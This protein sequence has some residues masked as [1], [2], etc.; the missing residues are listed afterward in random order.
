MERIKCEKMD[1][2]IAN[3]ELADR[4]ELRDNP[5]K[6]VIKCDKCNKTFKYKSRLAAQILY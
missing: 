3:M 2:I 5:P 4:I 6:A 1:K